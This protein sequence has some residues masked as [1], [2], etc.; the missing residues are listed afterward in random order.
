MKMK[1][2]TMENW[3]DA[4][5]V[6]IP[7]DK[8]TIE[9]NKNIN[10]I[11]E[12]YESSLERLMLN[13]SDLELMRAEKAVLLEI[14]NSETCP[15]KRRFVRRSLKKLNRRGNK[16]ASKVDRLS[17]KLCEVKIPYDEFM[18]KL[19]RENKVS[20]EKTLLDKMIESLST[21]KS[22]VDEYR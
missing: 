11:A 8:L 17:V 19:V 1:F 4:E 20:I 9:E 5:V 13:V 2:G 16:Q 7:M 6:E 12:T 10:M 18:L 22:I 3:E 15:T 21:A 14:Y